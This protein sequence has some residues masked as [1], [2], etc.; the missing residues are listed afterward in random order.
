MMRSAVFFPDKVTVKPNALNSSSKNYTVST[1]SE[2]ITSRTVLNETVTHS[3][4]NR[5]INIWQPML[6]LWYGRPPEINVG[7][8]NTAVFI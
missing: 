4:K 7:V 8:G 6:I 3:Y 2:Y 5:K 1:V